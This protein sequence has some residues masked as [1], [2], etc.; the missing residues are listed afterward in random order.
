MKEVKHVL[1]SS[2]IPTENVYIK[3]QGKFANGKFDKFTNF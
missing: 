1:E 2:D 3:I